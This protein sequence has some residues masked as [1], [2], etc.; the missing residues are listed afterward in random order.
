[1]TRTRSRRATS[2]PRSVAL[3]VVAAAATLAGFVAGRRLVERARAGSGRG[4][5]A[6]RWTCA[7]GQVFR[8]RGADRHRVYWPVDA[9]ESE[10]VLD[11]RCPT[12]ERPL[13]AEQAA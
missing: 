3:A 4:A 13:A 12:C 11:G 1:M 6:E 2:L 5:P 7:C 9:P 10:P 8:V